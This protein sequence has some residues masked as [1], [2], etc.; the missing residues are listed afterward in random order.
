MR[1]WWFLLVCSCGTWMEGSEV[2]L[3]DPAWH[4]T[5]DTSHGDWRTSL[6]CKGGG[7]ARRRFDGLA[8]GR[9][10]L[11]IDH[12]NS[13]CTN[14]GR[15]VVLLPGG[16]WLDRLGDAPL[17]AGPGGGIADVTFTLAHGGAVDVVIAAD[18]G[19]ECW[20]EITIR[21]VRLEQ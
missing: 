7:S 11:R 21:E 5:F 16:A 14:A 4:V 12:S 8:A 3:D 13:E 2:A 6:G 10:H 15:A 19:L 9:W 17:T 18:G 1:A 20:G